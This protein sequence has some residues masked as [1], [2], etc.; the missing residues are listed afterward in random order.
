MVGLHLAVRTKDQ[1]FA[2]A[3]ATQPWMRL[4]TRPK[5]DVN[6]LHLA[7]SLL[8]RVS[9]NSSTMAIQQRR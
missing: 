6:H 3:N 5:L 4:D 8:S 1:H 7:K 2:A 9:L